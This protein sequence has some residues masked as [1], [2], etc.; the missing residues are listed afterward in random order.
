MNILYIHGFGSKFKPQSDKVK[1][2]SS[3]GIVYGVDID[4]TDRRSDITQQLRNVI[5]QKNIELLVGTSMGGY[6]SAEVGLMV[7]LPYVM[8]NPALNPRT[9]LRKYIGEGVDYYGKS[10]HL[11]GSTVEEYDQMA[12]EKQHGLLLLDK[13]DKLIDYKETVRLLPDIQTLIFEGGSH[14]FDH[15]NESLD[16]IQKCANTLSVV[17][18]FGER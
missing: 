14:R 11:E 3:L 9:T 5:I 12:L 18:G 16:A 13:G 8:I 15:I 7:G 2:L 17:L 6:F 4:Y 1:S 10:Y